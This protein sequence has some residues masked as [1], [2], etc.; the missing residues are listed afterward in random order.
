MCY[1]SHREPH[2]KKPSRFG[3]TRGHG[4]VR[5]G[6]H[7]RDSIAGKPVCRKQAGFATWERTIGHPLAQRHTGPTPARMHAPSAVVV[8]DW[9]GCI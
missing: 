4:Q 1:S 5:S 3:E 9:C 6:H 8:K 2:M 7:G